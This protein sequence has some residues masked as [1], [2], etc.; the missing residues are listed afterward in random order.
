MIS[1]IDF[2]G[3]NGRGDEPVWKWAQDKVSLK[4]SDEPV[5]FYFPPP[6]WMEALLQDIE[7]LQKIDGA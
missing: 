1:L 5:G 3:M 2:T 6:P 7:R 4:I